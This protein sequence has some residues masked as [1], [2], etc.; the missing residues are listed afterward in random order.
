MVQVV[1]TFSQ[2]GLGNF[3]NV[4]VLLILMVCFDTYH[5]IHGVKPK[6]YHP[7]RLEGVRYSSSMQVHILHK[8]VE[9]LLK[10]FCQPLGNVM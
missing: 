6:T 1:L 3:V 10:D 7:N 8:Y 2:Q 4:A 5:P 9:I